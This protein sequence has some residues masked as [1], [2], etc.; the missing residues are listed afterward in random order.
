MSHRDETEPGEKWAFDEEVAQSFDD[1]LER[2]IPQYSV[3]RDLVTDLALQFIGS[4]SSVVDLGASRGEALARLK[5]RADPLFDGPPSYRPLYHAVEVSQSMLTILRERWPQ[6]SDDQS[7]RVRV[8]ERDLRRS[9]PQLPEPAAATLC[10]LTLQ[11]VPIEY[12]QRVLRDVWRSTKP[13]GALLLVEKVLGA[14]ADLDALFVRTYYDL[15]GANGYSPQQI[16][17]K[18]L[19]LEGVLVPVTTR[20]NEE[21]LRG[22]GFGEVDL[23]WCWSNFRGWIAVKTKEG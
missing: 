23:F 7:H 9:Y 15:K 12:R 4:G 5:E 8:H 1:M 18:R 10:V 16:E 22:A 6:H 3:M 20:M 19:S 13:G 17:R 2:S 21:L 14:T 11:F